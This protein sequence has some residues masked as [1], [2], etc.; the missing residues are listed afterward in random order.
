MA[1]VA[2]ERGGGG[3]RRDVS[4]GVQR[5][6]SVWVDSQVRIVFRGERGEP[7]ELVGPGWARWAGVG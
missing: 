7:G 4:G 5:S 1:A 3:G 6:A 2:A